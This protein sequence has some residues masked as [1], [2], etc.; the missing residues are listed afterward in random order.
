MF[1]RQKFSVGAIVKGAVAAAKGANITGK[2]GLKAKKKK[3]IID[4]KD[5]LKFGLKYRK[6]MQIQ[7]DLNKPAVEEYNKTMKQIKSSPGY[8]GKRK[9]DIKDELEAHSKLMSKL[10]RK[11]KNLAQRYEGLPDIRSRF[12]GAPGR[13]RKLVKGVKNPFKRAEIL[14]DDLIRRFGPIRDKTKFKKRDK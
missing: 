10:F 6:M 4:K 13:Q 2:A 8:T 11:S 14:H 1:R 9:Q 7:K 5:T 3:E 12:R